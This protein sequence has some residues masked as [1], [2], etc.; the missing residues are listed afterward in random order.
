MD[1]PAYMSIIRPPHVEN[2]AASDHLPS[3]EVVQIPLSNDEAQIEKSPIPPS[4]EEAPSL[5]M[6][7]YKVFMACLKRELRAVKGRAD[8]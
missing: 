7:T 6:G 8:I 5:Q 2:A 4:N 3:S 1:R